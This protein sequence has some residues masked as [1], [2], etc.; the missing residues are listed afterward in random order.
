MYFS[1]VEWKCNSYSFF[2]FSEDTGD[3]LRILVFLLYRGHLWARYNIDYLHINSLQKFK[4]LDM[5]IK[6][7]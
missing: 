2:D 1:I 6:S 4:P 7:S 5:Q 3:T